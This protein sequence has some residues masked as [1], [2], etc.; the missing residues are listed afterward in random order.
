MPLQP[1]GK[2][3]IKDIARDTGVSTTT[4]INV[5]K[6]R[7]TEVSEATALRVRR[8][9]G[10]LGYVRNLTAASLVS[11][12]SHAIALIVVN[13]Y[14]PLNEEQEGDINPFYGDLILRLEHQARKRGYMLSLYGGSE[15]DYVDF[16]LQ[17]NV[18][19]AILLGIRR[20]ELPRTVA[21]QGVP[22]LLI[23]SAIDDPHC[24][25][26][27]TDEV[28]GGELAAEHLLARGCR[29]LMFVGNTRH[30]PQ[31][32][33][34]LRLKG[35]QNAATRQGV[36]LHK[37][38]CLATFE[39]GVRVAGQIAESGATGVFAAADNLAAGL[40]T[41]L[42]D[43]GVRV[44]E[45]VAVVG[46]DNLLIARMIR[47]KLTTVDQKIGE[48]TRALLDLIENGRPGQKRIIQPELV[49]RES[50]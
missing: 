4:V 31:T 23:D 12:R 15:E 8:R 29:P 14:K 33:P 50:A 27:R 47:P 1:V 28:R 22:V 24:I 35:A 17:R 45:D 25:Q 11:R 26:V 21:R 32:M 16:I 37:T 43:R 40:I 38:D 18:D 36:E 49:V 20:P 41:G 44:P 5:L 2:P 19:A 39:E 34:S 7:D 10:E 9:A 3:T 46:Y 13:A 48:K 6:G 42:M 30:P